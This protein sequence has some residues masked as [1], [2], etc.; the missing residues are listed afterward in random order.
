M[1]PEPSVLIGGFGPGMRIYA[2]WEEVPWSAH[3]RLTHA[4]KLLKPDYDQ[5]LKGVEVTGT[6]MDAARFFFEV[7]PDLV[8][9]DTNGEWTGFPLRHRDGVRSRLHPEEPPDEADA[10]M[11]LAQ[12]RPGG[13]RRIISGTMRSADDELVIC[14]FAFVGRCSFTPF[15][16]TVE[17]VNTDITSGYPYHFGDV[18][19]HVT[20]CAADF[21]LSHRAV[22]CS[23]TDVEEWAGEP[24]DAAPERAESPAMAMI[25]WT[26]MWAQET[27]Y[28]TRRERRL[29]ASVP[30]R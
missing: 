4:T 23:D 2:V 16:E 14:G 25:D 15:F 5:Y 29:N 30:D 3:G 11:W 10:L 22:F 27:S 7:C 24:L 19:A 6:F 28:L 12:R 13:E 17:Q 8:H 20:E 9:R 18:T 1:K 21:E 26:A